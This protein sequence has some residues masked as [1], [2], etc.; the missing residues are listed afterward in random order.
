MDGKA[1]VC[2][3][4]DI[5]SRQAMMYLLRSWSLPHISLAMTPEQSEMSVENCTLRSGVAEHS[6]A[7]A[8]H[9]PKPQHDKACN[10]G[11]GEANAGGG[12]VQSAAKWPHAESQDPILSRAQNMNIDY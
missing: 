12:L 11:Y 6:K 1:F 4:Q 7:Y 5:L 10:C 3:Q 9:R 8:S 2:H